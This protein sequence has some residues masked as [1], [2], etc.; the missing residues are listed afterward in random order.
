MGGTN[1]LG[2]PPSIPEAQRIIDIIDMKIGQT[3]LY[4]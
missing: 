2:N 1:P 4:I 3:G